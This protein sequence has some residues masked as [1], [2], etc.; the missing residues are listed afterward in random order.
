M[1]QLVAVSIIPILICF[2]L[3]YGA[4]KKVPV[5]ET[6]VDGA[7]EGFDISIRIIPY[8]VAMIV[9]VGMFRASG[10]ID[11]LAIGMKPFLDW[12]GVPVDLIPLAITRSLSGSGA[13]GIFAEIAVTHGANSPITRT[14]AVMLG[15]SETTFYVLSVY[16]G[17]VGVKKFRHAI[18]AGIFADLVGVVVA[19]VV[20]RF[21]FY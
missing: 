10:A 16:F 9:A 2:F 4:Y 3:I 17:A 6:F 12:A 20:S 1:M 14:A 11:M 15:S 5:Y 19:L 13:R 21:V 18:T 7:K 8:L